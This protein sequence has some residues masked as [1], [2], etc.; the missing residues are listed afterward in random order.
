MF[1]SNKEYKLLQQEVDNQKTEIDQLKE[2]LQQKEMGITHF[3]ASLQ[4]DLGL[5]IEQHETVNGQHH[6]LGDL[7]ISIKE[8]FHSV[9]NI[10]RL[11]LEN[12]GVLKDEGNQL[13]EATA[14]MVSMSE[15]GKNAVMNVELLIRNLGD[16]LQDTSIKMNQLSS[17]SKEIENIVQVIR[18]IASQTNLLALNASIEAARAGDAGKGFAVVAE[19]VRKLAE[20][21][22][23]STDS[24][25]NLTENIQ[26]DIEETLVAT[27][28][29]TGIIMEG[30]DLSSGTSAMIQTI[31][32]IIDKVQVSVTQVMKSI[33][34][35]KV[36]SNGAMDMIENTQSIF[37]EANNLILKHIHDANE[38]D[39][40]LENGIR[41]IAK[42]N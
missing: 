7:I 23:Q 2:Q 27:K 19:E 14:E 16:Q 41:H 31:L 21:T 17:R 4:E 3:I 29:S 40:K 20:S 25:G 15:K 5:A 12:S 35:Q 36:H 10:S 22:A 34:E 13:L 18:E 33:E 11:S 28:K 8:R 26:R 9:E 42:I 39:I 37:E 24:I 30:I 1:K 38:V 32:T 6:V